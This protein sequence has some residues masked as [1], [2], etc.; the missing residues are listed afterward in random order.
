[1]KAINRIKLMI[2]LVGGLLLGS[3]PASSS[4]AIRIRAGSRGLGNRSLPGTRGCES[5]VGASAYRLPLPH[6]ERTSEVGGERCL[7]SGCHRK[8]RED[9]RP[10]SCRRQFGTRH[11][12]TDLPHRLCREQGWHDNEAD[13]QSGAVSRRR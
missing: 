4:W 7:Q 1:M 6:A 13:G 8:G 5:G 12:Q 3:L 11:R 10:L 9:S 2:G